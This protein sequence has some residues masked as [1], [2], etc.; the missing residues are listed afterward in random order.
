[1]NVTPL[2]FWARTC[3]AMSTTGPHVRE[4]HS[5][6]VANSSTTG[7]LPMTSAKSV[8]SMSRGGGIRVESFVRS[9]PTSAAVCGVHADRAFA[10]VRR[11]VLLADRQRAHGL[12]DDE[13]SVE[14]DEADGDVRAAEP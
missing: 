7:F 14:P 11:A 12:G 10:H 13:P 9:P 4:A 3:S 8:S 6:G 5:A 1:M 2:P